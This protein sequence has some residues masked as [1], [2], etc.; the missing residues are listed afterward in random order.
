MSAPTTVLPIDPGLL[1]RYREAGGKIAWRAAPKGARRPPGRT[2]RIAHL[3]DEEARVETWGTARRAGIAVESG[4]VGA[5]VLLL[6]ID[7][8]GLP[9]ALG[10]ANAGRDPAFP[11]GA[12]VAAWGPR[13]V[14][15]DARPRLQDL[16]ELARYAL[17]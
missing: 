8:R 9:S 17:A 5:L 14:P 13:T 1:A 15:A 3:H 4:P 12:I 2:A 16:I 10:S 7:R 11:A 6:E